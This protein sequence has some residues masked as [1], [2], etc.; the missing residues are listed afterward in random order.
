MQRT[1]IK[2]CGITRAEDAQAAVGLGANALG[3]V[4][5]PPSVRYVDID[6]A[7]RLVKGVPPFVTRVGLFVNPDAASVRATLA[8]VDLDLLQ[9][10]GDE[11]A[12]FCRQFARPYIKV[13]RMRPGIDLIEFARS[14]PDSRGLLLDTYVEDFGG[15]GRSFDWTMIPTDLTVP[16]VLAGGLTA[17]NVGEAIRRIRP[18]GVDVSSGVEAAKGIKDPHKIAAF[19]AAVKNADDPT[20]L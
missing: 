9:F 4:F 16:I 15:A 13:A 8:A 10:Q 14:Y 17:A 12:D 2:I 7:A 19:V 20:N 1:L 5:Y 11:S 18:A 6:Q 3:F